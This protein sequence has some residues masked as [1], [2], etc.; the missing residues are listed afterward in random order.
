MIVLGNALIRDSSNGCSERKLDE[1]APP[2]QD[3]F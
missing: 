3:C 1:N 2:A